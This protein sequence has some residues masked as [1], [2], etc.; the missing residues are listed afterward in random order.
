M[1]VE[2][3]SYVCRTC[4]GTGNANSTGTVEVKC[5]DCGG[6]GLVVGIRDQY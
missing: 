3:K 5:P 1:D 6:S 4:S 2:I